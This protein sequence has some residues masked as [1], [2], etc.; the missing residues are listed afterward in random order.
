MC[1]AV[2]VNGDRIT[3]TAL[4]L[5]TRGLVNRPQNIPVAIEC[6]AM[7]K[8]CFVPQCASSTQESFHYNPK[9]KGTPAL[10]LRTFFSAVQ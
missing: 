2:S 10:F 1:A 3:V 6:C 5:K 7:M 9:E 4:V 8:Y